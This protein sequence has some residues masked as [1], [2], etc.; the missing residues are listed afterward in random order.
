MEGAEMVTLA[1]CVHG[2]YV[3]KEIQEATTGE[4]LMC[5]VQP[6]NFHERNVVAVE[7]ARKFI[8]HFPQKVL[9]SFLFSWRGGSI[10]CTV[11]FFVRLK[12]GYV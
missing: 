3:Y 5:V 6:G 11:Q 1:P 4:T 2:Y 12:R 10:H 9:R 7:K 8:G